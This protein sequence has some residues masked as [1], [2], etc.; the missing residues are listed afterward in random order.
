MQCPIC[1]A[2]MR[3]NDRHVSLTDNDRMVRKETTYY[4][5]GCN[6]YITVSAECYALWFNVKFF[7]DKEGELS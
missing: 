2:V 5:P 4:C 6:D 3:F 1:N 7:S